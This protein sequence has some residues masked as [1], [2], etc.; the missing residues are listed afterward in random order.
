M[1]SLEDRLHTDDGV[2]PL[3]QLLQ[4]SL[5]LRAQREEHP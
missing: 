2:A 3:R 4:D 5:D 1:P